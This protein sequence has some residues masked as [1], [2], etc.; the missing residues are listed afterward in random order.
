MCVDSDQ[1]GWLDLAVIAAPTQCGQFGLFHSKQAGNPLPG[2]LVLLG[3]ELPTVVFN[4][5]PRDKNAL[6]HGTHRMKQVTV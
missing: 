3:E 4:V 2:R 1:R 5:E 6:I